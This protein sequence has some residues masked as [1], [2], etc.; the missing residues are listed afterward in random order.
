MAFLTEDRRLDGIFPMLSVFENIF[1]ANLNK[2]VKRSRLFNHKTAVNDANHFVDAIKIKTP[3]LEQRIEN[4]SGGNQQKVLVARW[5]NTE[6]E[7]LILDEPTRGIDVGAKAEI[8]RLISTLAG[9]GKSII[10][11]SS[12]LPEVMGMS[13]RIM[14]MH[15]GRVTGIIDN[16]KDLT[17]EEIMMYATG[18]VK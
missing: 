18:Q 13:D 14:I 8:H 15:E 10:M 9:Q 11:I 7:I 12:E 4:L 17:Q 16:R 3:N 5:L 1:L 2:Y 6:P